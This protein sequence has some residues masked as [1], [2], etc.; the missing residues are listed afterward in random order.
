MS[1]DEI[2]RPG[3]LIV[4]LFFLLMFGLIGGDCGPRVRDGAAS[5]ERGMPSSD[6]ATSADADTH[7]HTAP[8][9]TSSIVRP[10][11]SGRYLVEIRAERSTARRSDQH[12]WLV[13]IASLTGEWIQPTRL[14]F[15]GGMPQHGHGFETMPRVTDTLADGWFRVGGI[16]FH[17]AG[18][19]R[20]LVEFVGPEGADVAIF[21][22]VVPH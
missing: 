9:M 15:S 16:R 11:E 1:T 20:I 14:A 5:Q 4:G 6:A 22:V 21:E 3:A 13:R 12:A 19:W 18:E 17:M 8:D 7:A 10:S 2:S